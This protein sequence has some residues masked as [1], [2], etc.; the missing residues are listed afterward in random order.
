MTDQRYAPPQAMLAEPAAGHRA[1][2]QIDIGDAFREAWGA[3]W[4]NFG[5]LIGAALVSALVSIL[6]AA[7]IVGI[8][9]VLPVLGWGWFRFLLNV[10]DGAGEIRDQFAGFE[11]YGQSLAG[12]IGLWVLMALIVLAGQALQYLGQFLHS[13]PVLVAGT[14]LSVLWSFAFVMPRLAFVWYYLVDQRL[15]PAESIRACWDAT[16]NQKLI[17]FLLGLVSALITVVGLLFLVVGVI[18]ALFVAALMQA[19]AYRQLVGR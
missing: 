3:T 5:I 18:P 14:A 8:F 9:L 19:A 2:G 1:G 7:T 15:S 10:L 13:T 11:R 6:G 17:C 16:R 12:M 4:A